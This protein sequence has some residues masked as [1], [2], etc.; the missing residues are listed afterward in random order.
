M[1]IRLLPGHPPQ[2]ELKARLSWRRTL[3]ID[4]QSEAYEEV[5]TLTGIRHLLDCVQYDMDNLTEGEY[6]PDDLLNHED[7][8][9]VWEIVDEAGKVWSEVNETI[10]DEDM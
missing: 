5:P 4:P 6:G 2:Q 7:S 3:T 9:C 10:T 1:M 8:E